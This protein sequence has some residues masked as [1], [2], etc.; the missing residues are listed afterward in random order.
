MSISVIFLS[1]SYGAEKII[2]AEQNNEKNAI[3]I[4]R[5]LGNYKMYEFHAAI[6]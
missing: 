5:F 3:E 1:A 6:D 4:K 2:A